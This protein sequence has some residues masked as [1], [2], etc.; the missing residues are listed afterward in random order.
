MNKNA[1]GC[2][3]VCGYMFY[4]VLQKYLKSYSCKQF[5][6]TAVDMS[7]LHVTPFLFTLIKTKPLFRRLQD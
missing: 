1:M 7:I 2:V 4:A 6:A 3:C 5:A